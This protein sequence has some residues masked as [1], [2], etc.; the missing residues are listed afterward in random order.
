MAERYFNLMKN[1]EFVIE[2]SDQSVRERTDSY[3]RLIPEA[4][5]MLKESLMFY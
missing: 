1:K 4:F 2:L 5:N 3:L